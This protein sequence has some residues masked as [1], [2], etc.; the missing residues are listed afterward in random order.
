MANIRQS[1]FPVTLEMLSNGKVYLRDLQ[2]NLYEI[3]T[4]DNKSLTEDEFR[5]IITR[6]LGFWEIA[7]YY[8]LI[9]KSTKV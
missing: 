8:T 2:E 6:K 7:F 1:L 5:S 9:V 4:R 3:R